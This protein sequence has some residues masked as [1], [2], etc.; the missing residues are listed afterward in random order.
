MV[1]ET[2]AAEAYQ[3]VPPSEPPG[4]LRPVHGQ[5]HATAV[6][7]TIGGVPANNT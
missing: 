5:A 7:H 1:V 3:T 4:S 6:G 2:T